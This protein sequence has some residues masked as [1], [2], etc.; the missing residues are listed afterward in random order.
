MSGPPSPYDFPDIGLLYD[1]IRPY[2]ARPDV[3]FYVEEATRA[4]GPVLEVGCG[5]GRILLPTARAGVPITGLDAS[6]AMLARCRERL[7]A[8]PDDV[9]ARVALHHAD[10]R[11]FALGAPSGA[12]SGRPLGPP[13]ALVTAPF[14]VV[15]HLVTIDDQLRF[16]AAV[17]RHLA[18]RGRLVFDVFNP[19]FAAMLADRSAER[20]DTPETPLP[21]GRTLRRT[22]RVPRVRWTEQVNE[23][24]LI[25]YV[26]ERPGAAPARHVHAF[27]MRW[28]LRAELEHL[29][30][31]AGFRVE[32]V[33][34]GFD[35][36]PL[37]DASP[38]Q[39]V[40]AV[41]A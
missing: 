34:G 6:P 35:R 27:D 1:A 5:T 21:D 41:R 18:P 4:G 32:A 23:V 29:L 37:T 3:A 12:P 15:Q 9:R 7:A 10:A 11:D 22:A 30:A 19:S 14:R 20:E 25:Y 40:C 36:S 17:A 2:A 39:V 31:R 28:F 26:A 33:Y 38:E 16:L 24:E 8:E 13:F